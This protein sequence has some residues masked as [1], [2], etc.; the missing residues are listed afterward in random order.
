MLLPAGVAGVLL[1]L[2]QD[3]DICSLQSGSIIS[4][5]SRRAGSLLCTVLRAGG[6]FPLFVPLLAP[7]D[8]PGYNVLALWSTLQAAHYFPR[9]SQ[10]QRRQL[11]LADTQQAAVLCCSMRWAV[12]RPL[13]TPTTCLSPL[14]PR[15]LTA[16]QCSTAGSGSVSAMLLMRWQAAV[17]V[18]AS[19]QWQLRLVLA[20][21]QSAAAAVICNM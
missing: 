8:R 13:S 18:E 19:M 9:P 7:M 4:G 20:G 15:R 14:L 10:Q 11:E 5:T 2:L 16:R 1:L 3:V 12:C 17:Q 21:E 6:V